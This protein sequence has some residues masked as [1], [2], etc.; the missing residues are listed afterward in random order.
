MK[1]KERAAR[2]ARIAELRAENQRR[3]NDIARLETLSERE[4]AAAWIGAY[5]KYLNRDSSGKAW[6]MYLRVLAHEHGNSFRMLKCESQPGGWHIVVTKHAYLLPDPKSRGYVRITRRQFD[7]AWRK[8][9][10]RI[11]ALNVGGSNGR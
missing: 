11:A 2:D 6:W 7:A 9:V 5:F 10:A 8:H 1:R 4:D 3:G